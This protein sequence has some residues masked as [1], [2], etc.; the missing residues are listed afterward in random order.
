MEYNRLNFRIKLILLFVLSSNSVFCDFIGSTAEDGWLLS[1]VLD[2]AGD[3]GY[4]KHLGYGVYT[5]YPLGSAPY[6]SSLTSFLFLICFSSFLPRLPSKVPS[7]LFVVPFIIHLSSPC[8]TH[9][10]GPISSS[11]STTISHTLPLPFPSPSVVTWGKSSFWWQRRN[12]RLRDVQD[13]STTAG[14]WGLARWKKSKGEKVGGPEG[15]TRL[16]RRIMTGEKEREITNGG[17]GKER[18]EREAWEKERDCDGRSKEKRHYKGERSQ[19]GITEVY[20]IFIFVLLHPD[21]PFLIIHVSQLK[22]FI[23]LIPLPFDIHHLS[24]Q[25]GLRLAW[26]PL[27]IWSFPSPVSL[28]CKCMAESD[29]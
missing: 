20:A 11:P 23:Y 8:L 21:L 28:I 14:V 10:F 24:D 16:E 13:P 15:G 25:F 2:T 4:F 19:F 22:N 5:L 17:I 6:L 7:F 9:P 29:Y 1:L 18:W 12:C 27:L 3:Q 26:I